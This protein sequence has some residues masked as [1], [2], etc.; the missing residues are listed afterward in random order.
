MGPRTLSGSAPHPAEIA[1]GSAGGTRRGVDGT[2][3]GVGRAPPCRSSSSTAGGPTSST[4]WSTT[5]TPPSPTWPSAL[6]GGRTDRTVEAEGVVLPGDRRLDRAGIRSGAAVRLVP[7]AARPTVGGGPESDHRG[8]TGSP[9]WRWW[10][11]S[12]PGRGPCSAPGPG[13]WAARPAPSPWTTTRC[14]ATTPRW[15]SSPTAPP[16]SPTRGRSTAR[17]SGAGPRPPPS[18]WRR[19]RWPGSGRSRS[20]PGGRST[21]TVPSAWWPEPAGAGPRSRSTALPARR[22]RS[23]PSRWRP[24]R[25]RRRRR[26][27]RP[28]AS[29]PS[30]VRW[31]SA[32]PWWPSPG[33]GTS[34]C[35]SS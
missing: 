22:P 15:S 29:C 1:Q 10:A 9:R 11:G 19:A 20:W 17:G 24:P 34:P 5:P 2:R 18:T 8:E 27:R 16:P 32:P 13:P 26:G 31:A 4:S 14:R 6:T 7:L 3:C 33:G 28:S 12:T 23:R 30:S 35:S 25:R 21:T